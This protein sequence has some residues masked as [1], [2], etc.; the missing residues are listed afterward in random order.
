MYGSP[1][2]CVQTDKELP[3][4][5]ALTKRARE[6]DANYTVRPTPG[7]VVGVQQ[8]LKEQLKKRIQILVKANPTLAKN[9]KIRVKVTGDGTRISHSMHAVVMAFVVVEDGAN[10]NSPGGNHTIAIFNAGEKYDVLSEA[11]VDI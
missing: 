7:T 4:T 5:S 10:P 11:L 9:A 2:V 8:S 6:L 3:H 1:E